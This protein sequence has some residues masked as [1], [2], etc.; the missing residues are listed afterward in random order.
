MKHISLRGKFV[1]AA[2][3]IV[4]VVNSLIFMTVATDL[5]LILDHAQAGD[6]A[7]MC[8]TTLQ[9]VLLLLLWYGLGIAESFLRTRFLTAGELE[10]KGSIMKSILQR[11][12]QLFRTQNDAYYLNLLTAD[13]D[14]YR[15]DQ[16]ASIPWFIAALANFIT[17]GWMI[18]R[19]D[20]LLLL[21]GCAVIVLPLLGQN[22]FA[23]LQNKAKLAVSIASEAHSGVL[24]ETIEGYAAIKENNAADTMFSRYQAV[25]FEKRRKEERNIMIA[26]ISQK[27]LNTIACLSNLIGMFV[28][29]LLVLQGHFSAPM[30]IAATSY[31]GE[32][33]SAFSSMCQNIVEYRSTRSIAEKLNSERS[34]SDIFCPETQ[35]LT[36][37]TIMY[38]AVG[39]GFGDKQLYQNFNYTFL[40]GGCYCI[41]GESGSGKSTLVKLLLKHYENYAGTIK[42][43]GHDIRAMAEDE[44]YRHVGL[45]SQTP[46]LFNASLYENITMFS[47][48]PAQTS[49]EYQN[50]LRALN[51]ETLAERVQNDALGDFGDNISGGERQRINIARVLRDNKGI[52]IFDEPTTGLDPENAKMINDFIFGLDGVTRIVISHD[53]SPEYL[54]CFDAVIT[55]DGNLVQK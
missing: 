14:A 39:F 22:L 18:F 40:P 8:Q 12:L 52:I 46:Y 51:L 33:S 20:P 32:F 19:L 30:M 1:L 50:L 48:S 15:T 53:W 16:L 28:G 13:I 49:T 10:M 21:A 43:D 35:R 55:V 26:R 34:S 27:T 3:C 41:V 45:V 7:A 11:P 24:K 44:L 23:A 54:D 36:S 37:S 29:G 5:A 42:L 2:A 31:F 9:A 4:S 25:S 6:G 38:E 47:N 17:A